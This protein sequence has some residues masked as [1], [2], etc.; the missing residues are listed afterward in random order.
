MVGYRTSTWDGK[1]HEW[2][3]F[4]HL[5]KGKIH[6]EY[7]PTHWAGSSIYNCVM[8]RELPLEKYF[9]ERYD[10][11]W[12]PYRNANNTE[13]ANN[14]FWGPLFSGYD[15]SYDYFLYGLYWRETTGSNEPYKWPTK[16]LP[17]RDDLIFCDF[18]SKMKSEE[19]FNRFA[20]T[21]PLMHGIKSDE[22][23]E[24][25]LKYFALGGV[26]STS[27]CNVGF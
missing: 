2:P 21:L 19:I 26:R 11:P 14:C 27:N 24:R 1:D 18:N 5:K 23:R 15:I 17:N 9:Y 12:W 4:G 8:L 20:G 22:I 16:N 7:V 3:I 25:M 13:T 6:N 10:N